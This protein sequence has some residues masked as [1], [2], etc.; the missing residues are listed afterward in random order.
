MSS[1]QIPD[2]TPEQDLPAPIDDAG[3]RQFVFA[4]LVAAVTAGLSANLVLG[5]SRTAP[6][7]GAERRRSVVLA[8]GESQVRALLPES[9]GRPK[10]I[11]IPLISSDRWMLRTDSFPAFLVRRSELPTDVQAIS[12][13][14]PHA[15][16]VVS[17]QP[18]QSQF[19]CPC[20]D[21]HFST[22]GSRIDGPSPRGLDPLSLIFV[23]DRLEITVVRYRPNIADR[24]E[25][26]S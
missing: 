25:I 14:C 17:Y 22:D 19:A 16:C 6:V 9:I 4:G 15:G 24:V 8:R 21:A 23:D 13:I 2:E 18:R 1:A 10:R 20:H 26:P 11:S 7:S 3:R 5:A 12:A